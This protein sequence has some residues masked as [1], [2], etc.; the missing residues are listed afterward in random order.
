VRN[1]L[2]TV[3]VLSFCIDDF[4]KEADDMAAMTTMGKVMRLRASKA[5]DV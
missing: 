5:A 1:Q 4:R 2:H 3:A